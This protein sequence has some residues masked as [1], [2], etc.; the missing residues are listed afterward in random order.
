MLNKQKEPETAKKAKSLRAV[1][2]RTRRL[3]FEENTSVANLAERGGSYYSTYIWEGQVGIGRRTKKQKKRFGIELKCFS[4]KGWTETTK[5][6]GK[7][8]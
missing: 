8:I 2:E 7:A 1:L 5:E 6:R 3:K 4:S